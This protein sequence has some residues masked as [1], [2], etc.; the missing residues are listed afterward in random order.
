MRF[1][2]LEALLR[3][4][5]PGTLIWLA[6]TEQRRLEGAPRLPPLSSILDPTSVIDL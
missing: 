2:F 4:L 3:R 5:E 6:V 1:D